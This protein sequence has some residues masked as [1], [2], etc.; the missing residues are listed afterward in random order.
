[1]NSTT[2]NDLVRI[3]IMRQQ[4]A[5]QWK[6]IEALALLYDSNKGDENDPSVTL[7]YDMVSENRLKL[8]IEQMEARVQ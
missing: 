7:A 5:E 8:W 2:S 1:M 3:T 6:E 4:E